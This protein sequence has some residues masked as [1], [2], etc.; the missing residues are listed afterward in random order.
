MEPSDKKQ[1]NKPQ[2]HAID[3]L[4]YCLSLIWGWDKQV[5][6]LIA[7]SVPVV[8]LLPLCNV[9]LPKVII[10]EIENQAPLLH[11]I[12]AVLAIGI[13][14]VI[15]TVVS[16]RILAGM[17]YHETYI[18]KKMQLWVNS[19]VMDTDYDNIDKPASQ[20]LLKK[21]LE[22]VKGG[23]GE[24]ILALPK[25]YANILGNSLGFLVYA[26]ILST[27]NPIII[28][29]LLIGVAL[30]YFVYSKLNHWIFT[31][32]D[33]WLKLDLKLSYLTY[34]SSSFDVAKDIR[35]YHMRDWFFGTFTKYMKERIRWTVKMQLCYYGMNITNCVNLL[36]RDGGA[37]AYLIYLIWKGSISVSDF[38]LYLGVIRGFADWCVKI[39]M[40]LGIINRMGYNLSDVRSYMELED[41]WNREKGIALPEKEQLPC[42]IELEKVCYHY[43][44]EKKNILQDIN[45]TIHPGEKIALVGANGAGKTTLVKLLCGLYRPTEGTIKVADNP[46]LKYNR[47]EYYS[48]FAPVFQDICLLPVTVERNITLCDKDAVDQARLKE[49]LELSGFGEV[50]K[51]L[52]KGM[53]TLLIKDLNKDGVALSGGEEQKLILARALYKNASIMILDEPTAALDPIA[54]NAMYLKYNELTKNTTSIFI[55][56]RLASTRFCDRILYLENGRIQ[57]MGTH[58]ELLALG[59]SYAKMFDVQAEYYQEHKQGGG[60]CDE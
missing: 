34:Q 1:K 33:K 47:E 40:E 19:K 16:Q 9:Y 18:T 5:L 11:M 46:I 44:G 32:R 17:K 29:L 43:P 35:L 22:M 20:V 7:A 28:V 41:H 37:Y 21:A 31:N 56:H 12:L 57:E 6:F 8:L 54:E 4:N 24:G 26:G 13:L 48:L 53:D 3:N 36:F 10:A 52:P 15:F 25:S 55:S 42:S 51:K 60:Q 2:Y 59:G 30:Q 27:L 14:Q 39:V 45:L 38:V 58:E 49:C 50:V 23:E